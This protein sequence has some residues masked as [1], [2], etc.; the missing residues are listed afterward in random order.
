MIPRG[1]IQGRCESIEAQQPRP[2]PREGVQHALPAKR[3]NLTLVPVR[4][5]VA[6]FD[7]VAVLGLV[8]SS[9]TSAVPVPIVRLEL[10]AE[11]GETDTSEVVPQA[12]EVGIAPIDVSAL[13]GGGNQEGSE[14]H[15]WL[16]KLHELVGAKVM[17]V[18]NEALK[19][20]HHAEQIGVC[21]RT[22]E[23]ELTSGSTIELPE[24]GMRL[25][26]D[27]DGG[28]SFSAP[29]LQRKGT[30]VGHEPNVARGSDG[31]SGVGAG[32]SVTIARRRAGVLQPRC[33]AL[34]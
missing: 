15:V 16:R 1:M 11:I 19:L 31:H 29:S 17:E 34:G 12:S 24:L 3:I 4:E 13:G 25:S 26:E 32:V 14:A 22:P 7:Q 23:L 33:R 18:S 6:Q 20:R 21:D 9:D 2:S 30:V 28:A 5:R 10:R 27:V 8:T